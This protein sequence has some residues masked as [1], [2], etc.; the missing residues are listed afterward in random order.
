[1]AATGD[2]GGQEPF[3]APR[4]SGPAMGRSYSD[5]APIRATA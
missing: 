1:M 2:G 4:D 5:I 3:R